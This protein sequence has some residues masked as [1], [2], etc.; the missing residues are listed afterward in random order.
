[1]NQISGTVFAIRNAIHCYTLRA[2]ENP[3]YSAG[4]LIYF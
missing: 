2:E 4:I 1:M 3:D